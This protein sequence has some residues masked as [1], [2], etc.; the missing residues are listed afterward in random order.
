MSYKV[1]T[2]RHKHTCIYTIVSYHCQRQYL[3]QYQH[4]KY[5][6]ITVSHKFWFF[7]GNF[8]VVV[9]GFLVGCGGLWMVVGGFRW[10]WVDVD[11]CR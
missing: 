10:L 9:G 11:D 4:L 3:F 2:H 1:Y 7:G 8:W 6:S 5:S